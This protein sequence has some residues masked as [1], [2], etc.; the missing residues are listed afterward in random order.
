MGRELSLFALGAVALLPL[1]VDARAQQTDMTYFIAKAPIDNGGDLGGLAGADAYCQRLA[2]AAGA[3]NKTWRAYLSTNANAAGGTVNARD[4][5]GSGPW[6]NARG[7]IIASDVDEL[8]SKPNINKQTALDEQGN[9]LRIRGDSPNTID[10]LTGSNPEGR[11]FASNLD[12]TCNNW[13]SDN[14]GNA[15]LGHLDRE[16]AA[17]R[18]SWNAAHRSRDCS[19]AGFAAT[20]DKGLY[21]FA[22]S[23]VSLKTT[24]LPSRMFAGPTQYPPRQFKAY[25]IMV[26]NTLATARDKARYDMI[27]DAYVSSLLHYKQVNAPLDQQMVTVWPIDKDDEAT[28]IEAT[29][30]EKVCAR[31]VPRYGL[32]I[33]QDAIESAKKNK[34]ILN[35]RGPYL[36]AWAPGAKKGDSDALV[37]VSNLSNVVNIEDAKTVFT[38]WAVEIQEN[39][40]LWNKGWDVDKLAVLV[41]FWADRYGSDILKYFKT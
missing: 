28:Q 20:G 11:A 5:I 24:I 22:V 17:P 4:R 6:W 41:R 14:F 29:T 23:T 27:C 10:V 7:I 21:C 36:L 33:A 19:P 37:L 9:P 1:S 40:D 15:M 16:G 38:R 12:L 8:H 34:A 26:F 31:A 18:V 2:S 25:G 39:P 13:T 35:G 32:S 3:G 30:R